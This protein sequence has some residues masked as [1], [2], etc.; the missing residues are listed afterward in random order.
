MFLTIMGRLSDRVTLSTD[1]TTRVS[2][3]RLLLM[4]INAWLSPTMLMPMPPSTVSADRLALK[5][6]TQAEKLWARRL[7]AS[8]LMVL[9]LLAQVALATLTCTSLG[10]R[11]HRVVRVFTRLVI[12]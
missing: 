2:W 3:F 6:L 11:P 5:L 10:G 1:E 4:G 12:L 8:P 7:V 9:D